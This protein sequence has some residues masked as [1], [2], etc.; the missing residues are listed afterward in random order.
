MHMQ[1]MQMYS[2]AD[3]EKTV[4]LASVKRLNSSA[5][6]FPKIFSVRSVGLNATTK[7]K[8]TRIIC[9]HRP[10]KALFNPH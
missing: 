5:A 3:D 8:I 9:D 6:Y 4:P 10:P 7:Q 2:D 1:Y